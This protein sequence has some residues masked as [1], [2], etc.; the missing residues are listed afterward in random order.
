MTRVTQRDVMRKL[1]R[2]LGLNE[3]AVCAAYAQAERDGE[4]PRAKNR[5]GWTSEYYASELWRDGVKKGWLSGV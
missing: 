3:R 4:A 1:V 2:E 5:N